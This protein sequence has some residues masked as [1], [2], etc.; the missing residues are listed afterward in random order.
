VTS[1]N[2]AFPGV[3]KKAVLPDARYQDVRKTVVV[4]ITDRHSHSVHLDVEAGAPVTSENVP[5]RL[6]R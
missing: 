3:A 6:L 2:S 5:F 4:V 1:T